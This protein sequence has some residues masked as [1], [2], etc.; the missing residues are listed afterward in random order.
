MAMARNSGK[1]GYNMEGSSKQHI[2]WGQ[3]VMQGSDGESSF[4]G[5]QNAV[6]EV[7]NSSM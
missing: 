2:Q 5:G 3:N 4:S 6:Q 7:R 1:L